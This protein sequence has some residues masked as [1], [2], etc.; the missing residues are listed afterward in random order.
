MITCSVCT[1]VF[2]HSCVKITSEEFRILSD[3][4]K[5]YDWSCTN[6]RKI[7]SQ[8]KELKNLIL[9]LQNDIQLLK[10]ENRVLKSADTDDNFENIIEEINER[11]Y[12][13][14]NIIIFGLPEQNQDDTPQARIQ[15]DKQDV[16]NIINCLD[17]DFAVDD[18]KP[19]RLGRYN[20]EKI[21]PVKITL[22]DENQVRELVKNVRNLKNLR[23]SRYKKVF[24][25]VDR[26]QRQLNHYKKLKEE[27]DKKNAIGQ[28][29][30]RIKYIN[31]NP[32]IVKALN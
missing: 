7:G 4:D 19:N 1:R 11:N 13:K 6:C 20:N 28:D 9:S 3:P 8:L 31:G 26:T 12:R 29:K 16:E 22:K 17:E 2:K 15:K 24:V 5:G 27:V 30:V 21:R 25:S 18:I 14:R 10:D 23:N 32:K